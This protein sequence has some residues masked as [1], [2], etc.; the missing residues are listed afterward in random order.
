MISIPEAES[1]PAPFLAD[2]DQAVVFWNLKTG[3]I[4]RHPAP[5]L[6]SFRPIRK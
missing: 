5:P 4:E 1:T 3:D 6:S 2:G